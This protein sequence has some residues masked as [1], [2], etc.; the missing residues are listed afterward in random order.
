[1]PLS[2]LDSKQSN[3]MIVLSRRIEVKQ[4]GGCWVITEADIWLAIEAHDGFIAQ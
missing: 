1:M 3:K 2:L 4:V